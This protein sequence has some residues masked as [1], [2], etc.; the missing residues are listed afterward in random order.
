MMK[1]RQLLLLCTLLP[2]AAQQMTN[3]NHLPRMVMEGWGVFTL[4]MPEGYTI[5][6]AAADDRF[7]FRVV[8]AATTAGKNEGLPYM[9]IL[10]TLTPPELPEGESFTATVAGDK[11]TG[12]HTGSETAGG[13]S[14]LIMKKGTEG[15]HLCI[16]I[17][18]GTY[19]D[20]MFSLLERMEMKESPRPDSTAGTAAAPAAADTTAASAATAT[21]AASSSATSTAT[22]ATSTATATA[23]TSTTSTATAST[24]TSA[25]APDMS[26]A[27]PQSFRIWGTCTLPVPPDIQVV[28]QDS[29]DSHL[30]HFYDADKKEAMTIYSGFEPEASGTGG[31]PCTA[32]IAGD[33]V[34]GIQLAGKQEYLLERGTQGAVLHIV[35][36]DGAEKPRMLAML[37]SMVL[38]A[39]ATLPEEV[40]A[41]ARAVFGETNRLT[42]ELNALF[43]KVKSA[44]SAAAAVPR[45]RELLAA[46]QAQEQAMEALS[47]RYGRAIPS[48]VGTLAPSTVEESSK[49]SH[50]QR[51][52][53]ADCYGCAELQELLEDFMGL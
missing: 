36:Y 6:G 52:H 32:L 16:T 41:Q 45:M 12:V 30:L 8:P 50:I 7:T 18:D 23:A 48:F 9:E 13:V 2:A 39:P 22:A 47:K 14:T 4:P 40:K 26:A 44:N 11:V 19:R 28:V 46:L 33:Q 20:L 37:G 5:R 17:P 25:A 15:A 42:A 10:S 27:V 43:A 24:T 1:A 53:D 51:V 35:V 21:A 29:A 49:E 38:Q 34:R 31:K 3:L